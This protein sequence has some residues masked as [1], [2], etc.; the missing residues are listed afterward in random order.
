MGVESWHGKTHHKG[1]QAR[2]EAT[3]N[4]GFQF[5]R[6]LKATRTADDGLNATATTT[7]A[8]NNEFASKRN[9]E[10]GEWEWEP[11]KNTTPFRTK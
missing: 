10:V 3:T 7:R 5:G 1:E 6:I 8:N 11:H 2:I 4:L 9:P